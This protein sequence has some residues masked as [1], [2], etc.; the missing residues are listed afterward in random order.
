MA[1]PAV[2]GSGLP[3]AAT[4]P[5][6]RLLRHAVTLALDHASAPRAAV[7]AWRFGPLVI[8]SPA[9]DAASAAVI[10]VAGSQAPPLAADMVAIHSGRSFD[11][12]IAAAL[13]EDR[14]DRFAAFLA[15]RRLVVVDRI[16]R[17][18][19]GDRHRAVVHLLD[20]VSAA[21]TVWIV[22]TA[23]HPATGAGTHVDS[24]LCGGLVLPPAA[25]PLPSPAWRAA[26]GAEPSLA[27]IIRAAAR[28]HD[29][30]PAVVTGPSR[31]RTVS[32]ARSLA[33]YLAR[34]LTGRS[35][36]AIGAAC[37]GRDHSTVLHGVRV[38]AARIA[39]DPVFSAEVGRVAAT[40]GVTVADRAAHAHARPPDV[41]STTLVRRL[42]DRRHTR[43]R[44]A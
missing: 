21:G 24:R 19:R 42:R 28:L 2:T 35:L 6:C 43:R 44:L 11:R 5:S 16:D 15:A 14:L 7:D 29:V 25:S 26:R 37:G 17:V 31:G 34:R 38:C 20:H 39:G 36:Q 4:T 41:G 27:R 33:M 1:D 13:A 23:A 30:E 3:V 18:A 8:V 40:L 12:E 22:S 32:A 10:G 9:E